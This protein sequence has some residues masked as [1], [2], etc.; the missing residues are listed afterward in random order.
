VVGT[1][2]GCVWGLAVVEAIGLGV[3]EGRMTMATVGGGEGRRRLPW[4]C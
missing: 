1:A 3:G 2:R 4:V